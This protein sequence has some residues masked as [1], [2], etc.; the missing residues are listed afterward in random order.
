LKTKKNKF[1][2][3]ELSLRRREIVDRQKWYWFDKIGWEPHRGQMPMHLSK[4][5]K[6]LSCAGRQGGKTAWASV[7]ASAYM[8]AGP[9]KVWFGGPSYDL[10][11]REWEN[12][13]KCIQHP[14]NPHRILYLNSN[15]NAGT[16]YC[17]LSNGS[18][19]EGKSLDI[20]AKS[21]AIGEAIDLFVGCEFAQQ[22]HIGG[23][24][25]IWNG[26]IEGNLMTRRGDVIIPTT[27]KG[28][29]KWLYPLFELG[30]SGADPE[31]FSHQWPSWENPA[32]MEDP[33][34]L[35]RRMSKRAFDEQVRGLFISWS[36]AIWLVDCMY[37]PDKHIEEPIPNIPSWWNRIE[38]IDPGFSDWLFWIAA[39]ID[40]SGDIHIVDEFQAKQMRWE[41]LAKVIY[42]KR[43]KMYGKDNLPSHVPIYVDPESPR[44]RSEL[45]NAGLKLNPPISLQ[46]IPAVNDVWAGFSSAMGYF[47]GDKEFI[48]KSCPLVIEA[49]ENHEWSERYTAK[50]NRVELRDEYKHASDVMRYLQMV[51]IRPSIQPQRIKPKFGIGYDDLMVGVDSNA[52]SPGM[53]MSQFNRLHRVA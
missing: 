39:V 49:L 35:R 45:A 16:L 14:A 20:A 34:A 24:T 11:S 26:Q 8:I 28:K 43:V 36:G 50:G 51:T 18:T 47:G 46:C 41:D 37:D 53:P 40:S 4:A 44:A 32:W 12:F 48:S 52:M 27:P 19:A 30:M 7:E 10:V 6:R 5:R 21:P 9:F 2:R 33:V 25:G 31:V 29:D 1:T 23:D 42:E 13:V 3:G 17:R 22:R 15:K 38:V